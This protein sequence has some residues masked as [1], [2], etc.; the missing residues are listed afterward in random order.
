MIAG[1]IDIGSNTTK[2]FVY[3]IEEK[4]ITYLNKKEIFAYLMTHN[5]NGTMSEE[6]IGILVEAGMQLKNFL[7]SQSCDVIFAYATSAVRDAQNNSLIRE[8]FREHTGLDLDIL[9]EEQEAECDYYSLRYYTGAQKGLG[10]DLGG[11]SGQIFSFDEHSVSESVSLPIGILRTKNLIVAGDFP[12]ETEFDAID[13][14][15]LDIL[16]RTDRITQHRYPKIM[17][18]GG[19]ATTLLAVM[20]ALGLVKSNACSV[21]F[22]QMQQAKELL[23]AKEATLYDFLHDHASGREYTTLPGI[24]VL[25]TIGRYFSVD[26]YE[27][28]SN[29][30]REGYLISKGLFD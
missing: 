2:A 21:A 24:C 13:R 19:T 8:K 25:Q 7:I 14:H 1:I 6:G 15:I 26:S 4:T 29:G 23:L 9:S 18:M 11:G 27:I 5:Q 10:L 30:S 20:K 28:F 16:K 17:I 12:T 22:E 3:R